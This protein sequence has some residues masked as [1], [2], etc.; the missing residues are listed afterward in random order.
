MVARLV[1]THGRWLR[2]LAAMDP[3]AHV[4]VLLPARA[5]RPTPAAVETRL[6]AA[7]NLTQVGLSVRASCGSASFY[8]A[9]SGSRRGGM[10]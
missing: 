4:V 8:F 10:R 2:E 9:V 3:H 5:L 1:R 7:L 6:G